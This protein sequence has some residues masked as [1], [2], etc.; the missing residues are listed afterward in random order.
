MN[1]SQYLEKLKFV[2][3]TSEESIVSN[4]KNVDELVITGIYFLIHNGSIVYVGSSINSNARILNHALEREKVFDSYHIINMSQLD[5]VLRLT[6]A[7]FI[8]KFQPKYNKTLPIQDVFC[9]VNEYKSKNKDFNWHKNIK[10]KFEA[11]EMKKFWKFSE[12]DLIFKPSETLP[13]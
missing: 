12:L 8:W 3:D 4:K 2:A 7:Y 1:E 10:K 13:F 11:M 5:E 6:E 9:T